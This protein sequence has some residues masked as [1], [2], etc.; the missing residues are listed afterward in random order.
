MDEELGLRQQTHTRSDV[1]QDVETTSNLERAVSLRDVS[2]QRDFLPK[3]VKPKNRQCGMWTV[4][5]TSRR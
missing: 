5:S 2:V 3:C 4:K 1:Q